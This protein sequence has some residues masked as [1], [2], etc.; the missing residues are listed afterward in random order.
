MGSQYRSDLLC[1]YSKHICKLDYKQYIYICVNYTLYTCIYTH[2]EY[3]DAITRVIPW[4]YVPSAKLKPWNSPCFSTWEIIELHGALNS[5]HLHHSYVSLLE[6]TWIYLK[7]SDPK[8]RKITIFEADD[9]PTTSILGLTIS[10]WW[11]LEH[12]WIMTF[13][14]QL[15]MSSS[16]LT[17]SYFSED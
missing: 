16:Q 1:V 10:G 8:A 11:W 15:G 4:I 7:R 9:W 13:Q 3:I 17:N 6:A 5:I 2:T 12:E 14:K